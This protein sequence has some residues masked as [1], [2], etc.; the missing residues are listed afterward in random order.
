MNTS[1]STNSNVSVA[2]SIETVKCQK[3]EG[4]AFTV[5][6]YIFSD[7]IFLNLSHNFVNFIL[8]YVTKVSLPVRLLVLKYYKLL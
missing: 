8:F 4:N 7:Q 1:L 6:V 3:L 5:L 2:S